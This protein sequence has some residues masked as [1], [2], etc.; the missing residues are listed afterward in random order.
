MDFKNNYQKGKK[1]ERIAVAFLRTKGYKMLFTNWRHSTLEV[2]I[3]CKINTTIVFVEVKYRSTDKFSNPLD[4]ID[5]DKIEN[6]AIAAG[7]FT[8]KFQHS[9]PCRFDIIIILPS[10]GNLYKIRHYKDAFFPGWE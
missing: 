10:Q 9:G 5:E 2:D 3:I 7:H 6:L 8:E 4:A 1:G